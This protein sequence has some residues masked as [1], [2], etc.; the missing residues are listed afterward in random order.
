MAP[1]RVLLR[2]CFAL[3]VL[4]VTALFV[5]LQVLY[6]NAPPAEVTLVASSVDDRR[7]LVSHRTNC[8]QI[9]IKK[10]KNSCVDLPPFQSFS[11]LHSKNDRIQMSV[12]QGREPVM[13][14][15][16][17]F[18]NPSQI[19]TTQ[20]TSLIVVR[21]TSYSRVASEELC[22]SCIGMGVLTS[23]DPFATSE[24]LQVSDRT[25][26][27]V[28]DHS[29]CTVDLLEQGIDFDINDQQS[30]RQS[31][32]SQQMGVYSSISRYRLSK[33]TASPMMVGWYDT[34]IMRLGAHSAHQSFIITSQTTEQLFNFKLGANLAAVDKVQRLQSQW[35]FIGIGN[36]ASF[37]TE[38]QGFVRGSAGKAMNENIKLLRAVYWDPGPVDWIRELTDMEVN[39]VRMQSFNIMRSLCSER[40]SEFAQLP[41]PEPTVNHG[42]R[43]VLATI[44]WAELKEKNW[45]PFLFNGTTLW[46]Y[47]LHPGHVVCAPDI[48]LEEVASSSLSASID[49]LICKRQH[50]SSSKLALAGLVASVCDGCFTEIHLNGV[51]SYHIPGEI[52][53]IIA[54]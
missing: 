47:M 15:A 46:S 51:P 6:A 29:T 53:I 50:T 26:F 24:K 8:A 14:T 3:I 13:Q 25:I 33:D 20:E 49:C 48:D 28:L 32:E 34:K 40:P 31:T 30:Y 23:S 5:G 18:Y 17:W 16:K 35:L 12:Y 44:G 39:G 45:S 54:L 43:K 37:S 7:Q 19:K 22:C 38:R 4:K 2:L 1:L 27:G 21:E 42:R 36:V 10:K 52:S 41:L 11:E 9:K